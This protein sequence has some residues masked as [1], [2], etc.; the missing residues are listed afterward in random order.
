MELG[1]LVEGRTVLYRTVIYG[2]GIERNSLEFKMQLLE[3]DIIH[4]LSKGLKASFVRRKVV[5]LNV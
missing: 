5:T 1:F 2:E 4:G 3:R